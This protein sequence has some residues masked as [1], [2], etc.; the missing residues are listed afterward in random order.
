MLRAIL[1]ALLGACFAV[2]VQA[3]PSVH[4]TIGEAQ[5]V[6]GVAS[7]PVYASVSD[8]SD[9]AGVLL[10]V[11]WSGL[12][13]VGHRPGEAFAAHGDYV[14]TTGNAGLGSGC[15]EGC[16]T[17]SR[18]RVLVIAYGQAGSD[19]SQPV[20]WLDFGCD[21]AGGPVRLT[22]LDVGATDC[23]GNYMTF[24]ANAT[25][26]DPATHELWEVAL[27]YPET[28]TMTVSDGRVTGQTTGDPSDSP[29]LY[30]TW[31]MVK[32]LYR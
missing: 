6:G 25:L 13:L 29:L 23:G 2:A 31:T 3:L 19:L 26:E 24:L 4:L 7:V 27:G 22:C 11:E 1:G 16:S 15:V 32:A 9:V 20:M 17:G 28:G 10:D 14:H 30:P 18:L 5:A 8:G 21:G 12:A